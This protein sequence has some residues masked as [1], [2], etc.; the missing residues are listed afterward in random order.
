MNNTK[1][2]IVAYRV[3]PRTI[4]KKRICKALGLKK[5]CKHHWRVKIAAICTTHFAF[6][7]HYYSISS[8]I[9]DVGFN[10][11]TFK[12]ANS[13][14]WIVWKKLQGQR[15]FVS[16]GKLRNW[17]GPKKSILFTAKSNR[18]LTQTILS[19]Y[20]FFYPTDLRLFSF[21]YFK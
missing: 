17:N 12:K 11:F 3:G 7:P 13:Y 16:C 4:D 15:W 20:Y 14:P 9:A 21:L 5:L 8:N 10:R 1:P 2:W 18:N 19:C 6:F